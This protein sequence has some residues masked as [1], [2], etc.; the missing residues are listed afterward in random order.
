MPEWDWLGFLAFLVQNTSIDGV[1]NG[2]IGI[3]GRADVA[4]IIGDIGGI[5]AKCGNCGCSYIIP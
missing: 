1:F 2:I 5:S 3:L 4:K